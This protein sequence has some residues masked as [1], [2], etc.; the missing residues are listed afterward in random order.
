MRH[1]QAEPRAAS[2]RVRQLTPAGIAEV[3]AIAPAFLQQAGGAVEIY[4]SPYDRARQTAEYMA[5]GLGLAADRLHLAEPLASGASALRALAWAQETVPGD[6]LL[7]SH[8]PLVAELASLLLA[9]HM[10]A[11]I[12]YPPAGIV[13]LE[14]D[15]VGLGTAAM[16]WQHNPGDW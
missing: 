13:A 14:M 12:S 5:Q 6:A 3:Q 7:V 2:D 11:P 16:R 9:G 1:G 10:E 15:A 4:C 8:V